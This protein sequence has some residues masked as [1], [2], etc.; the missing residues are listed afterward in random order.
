LTNAVAIV[1]EPSQ[2]IVIQP[3][4]RGTNTAPGFSRSPGGMGVEPVQ[5]VANGRI[6]IEPLV[7]LATACDASR[8][9]A[10]YYALGSVRKD[11]EPSSLFRRCA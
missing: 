6:V 9:C 3:T 2:A 11:S 7:L 8:G 10:L 5:R 4:E 1:N